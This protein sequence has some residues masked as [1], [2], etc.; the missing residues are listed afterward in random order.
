MSVTLYRNR[1]HGKSRR[2]LDVSLALIEAM[3]ANPA[4]IERPIVVERNRAI[5][6][7]PPEPVLGSL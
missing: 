3:I 7:R 5:L 4:V 6:G 1:R 2:T